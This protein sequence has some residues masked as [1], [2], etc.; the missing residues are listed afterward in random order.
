MRTQ[1]DFVVVVV[2]IFMVD[3]ISTQFNDSSFEMDLQINQNSFLHLPFIMIRL[4]KYKI[5][6]SVLHE[7]IGKEREQTQIES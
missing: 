6:L 5:H 1:N 3:S 2:G 4:K 7:E